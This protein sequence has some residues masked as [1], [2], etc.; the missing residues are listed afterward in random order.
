MLAYEISTEYK[1]PSEIVFS[2][3][4]CFD[5]L[6]FYFIITS[7]QYE[8]RSKVKFVRVRIIMHF[9]SYGADRG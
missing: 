6:N 1:N 8:F 9:L 5:V 7:L 2:P 4:F 3:S